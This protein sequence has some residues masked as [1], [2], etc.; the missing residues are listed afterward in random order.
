MSAQWLSLI[1]TIWLQSVNGT[2]S[3]FP[4]YSSELKRILSISQLQLNNLASASDA[5]K[6]LGWLSGIA[7]AH[8][9][10]WL[11]LAIGSLLGLVGYGVQFLFLANQGPSLSYCHIF[12]LNILAGNSICWINTVCYIIAIRNF[13]LDRQVAVGLSTSYVGLS[14]KIYA[15]VVDVVFSGSVAERAR[16]FLLLNSV[17]PLMVCVAAAPLARELVDVEKSR[18]LE[19]GFFGMYAI[20]VVTGLF[21][22]ITSLRLRFLPP[23]PRWMVLVGMVVFLLL[24]LLVPCAESVRE[25]VQ[26]K[27]LIRVHD[28]EGLTSF[29]RPTKDELEEISRESD[30]GVVGAKLTMVRSVEFWL[31]F[32]V[33]M[34]GATIGLVYLNNLG[35]IGESRGCSG[36]SC[37]LVS[38]SSAFSFF[39]RLLPSL[40]D[41]FYP[42]SKRLVS[43]AIAMGGM[44]TPMCGAFFLLLNGHHISLYVSTAIIGTCTG[45]ITSI[46]VSTTTQLFGTK[47]F[48]VNH[49]IV[50]SNIPIGSFLFGDLAALLYRR[51]TCVGQNCYQLTFIIWGSLCVVG[52]LL[53]FV[54]HARTKKKL[55][56]HINRL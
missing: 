5:G 34:F 17:L 47:N 56:S 22:V 45:A 51:Q 18:K 36:T 38:V 55:C 29:A 3:N 37:S 12:A 24:P 46:S 44:M 15:V 40:L 53:A 13:P 4:A 1:A 23:P 27:C 39:G 49:N 42:R 50:V 48:G 10:L 6:L 32:G 54:L 2:N 9:P 30:F 16:A 11:V 25:G 19:R 31:Y 52:T 7:A 26:R 43:R 41:Y 33:Y 35:Q 8:L 14:A 28:D 21:A 20:T